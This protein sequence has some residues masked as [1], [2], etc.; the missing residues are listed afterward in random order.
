M[1]TDNALFGFEEEYRISYRSGQKELHIGDQGYGLSPLTELF[2][3]GRGVEVGTGW[4]DYLVNGY[5]ME[6]HL[7]DP[8]TKQVGTSATYSASELLDLKLNFLKKKSGFR[9]RPPE[10]PDRCSS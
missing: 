1:D 2:R 8:E 10:P 7:E 6:T 5:F 9:R 3:F 4:K